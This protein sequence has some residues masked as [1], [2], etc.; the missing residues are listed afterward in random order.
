MPNLSTIKKRADFLRAARA[1]Y[2]P[3]RGVVL[4]ARNRNDESGFRVGYTVTKKVG[5]AVIRNRVRRRLRE[6]ARIELTQAARPGFDYVLIG[7]K[8]TIDRDFKSL[9]GDLA[10]ALGKVHMSHNRDQA[11]GNGESRRQ[12][13]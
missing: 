1:Q 12:D 8:A 9:C 11:A 13:G 2:K 10:Y 6:A 4:Q 3:A 7:R 5:N